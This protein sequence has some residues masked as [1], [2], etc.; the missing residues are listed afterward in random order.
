MW[1]VVELGRRERSRQEAVHGS[2][3]IHARATK[4]RD[5]GNCFSGPEYV[6]TGNDEV[7]TKHRPIRIYKAKHPGD[8]NI[9]EAS[10]FQ[11]RLDARDLPLYS[12]DDPGLIPRTD[13]QSFD[14][15]AQNAT[16]DSKRRSTLVPLGINDENSSGADNDVVDV[17]ARSRDASVMKHPHIRSRGGIETAPKLLLALGPSV[18]RGCALGVVTQREYET[19]SSRKPLPN[20]G[21]TLVPSPFM[22]SPC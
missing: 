20:P 19:T 18:P 12:L 14:T 22:F 15:L 9:I 6:H 13:E 5:V 4:S 3:V 1:W 8:R 10:R 7:T 11:F 21:F 2:D 17:R 16:V